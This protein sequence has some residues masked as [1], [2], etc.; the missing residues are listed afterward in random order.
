MCPAVPPLSQEAQVRKLHHGVALEVY[1]ITRSAFEK[2]MMNGSG[3]WQDVPGTGTETLLIEMR[4]AA[5]LIERVVDSWV[6][7]GQP[8]TAEQLDSLFQSAEGSGGASTFMVCLFLQAMQ[9][10][11]ARKDGKE[12][13][14]LN[15]LNGMIREE[16]QSTTAESTFSKTPTTPAP[17]TSS[18]PIPP[19]TTESTPTP[20]AKKQRQKGRG[21]KP[22]R[23]K[24]SKKNKTCS[25]SAPVKPK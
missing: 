9:L 18:I 16:V 6:T 17:T 10:Y 4:G 3:G 13:G 8:P 19:S 14:A 23:S 1:Q 2:L 20:P 25:G 11:V 22:S 7:L 12:I 21:K 5:L 24:L 15:A